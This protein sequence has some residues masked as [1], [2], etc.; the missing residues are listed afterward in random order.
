QKYTSAS[1]AVLIYALEPVSAALFSFLVLGERLG[2]FESIGATL[3]L[4]SVIISLW[5]MASSKKDNLY[6]GEIPGAMSAGR[7]IKSFTIKDGRNVILR[8]PKI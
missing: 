3:I 7:V 1:Q 4:V 2:F 6:E 8:A 5:E